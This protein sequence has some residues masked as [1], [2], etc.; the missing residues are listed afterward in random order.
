[1]YLL[2]D[3]GGTKMRLAASYE[4]TNLQEVSLFDTPQNFED[5]KKIIKE[6][7]LKADSSPGGNNTCCGLPGVLNKEKDKLIAAPNLKEWIMKP[8][9]VE[10]AEIVGPRLYLENDAG[11]AGLGEATNGAGK[12]LGIVA[13]LTVG[14]GVGGVRI[15][16]GKIDRSVY[17]FEPGHQ[18]LILEEDPGV[19]YYEL[20]S[21][22][23]G[24]GLELR[25]GKK[26]EEIDNSIWEKAEEYLAIGIV[27]TIL[28]WSPDI[29][30][31]G[32]GLTIN[33]RFSLE[34]IN[35][36]VGK[37]LKVFPNLPDIKK[38]EL[39]DKAGLNGALIYLQD[40]K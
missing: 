34:K 6:F 5:A 25:F 4:G 11:L 3:I 20:E 13:Y 31:L 29:V 24:A 27:N 18:I 26:P 7:V 19:K 28:F 15:V 40:K 10:L 37:Y 38:C 1:M 23:A 21:L 39:G 2:I 33:E 22:V 32:G 36:Y 14:T 8:I 12:G 35:T 30:V 16:D 9:K 17:G